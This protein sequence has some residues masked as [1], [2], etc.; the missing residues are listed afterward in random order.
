M[1]PVEQ[2]LQCSRGL[3]HGG[4]SAT[5]DAAACCASHRG[6]VVR[7]CVLLRWHNE[8]EQQASD[9][10][11]APCSPPPQSSFASIASKHTI[12]AKPSTRRCEAHWAGASEEHRG[13]RAKSSAAFD[14]GHC[15]H[16]PHLSVVSA[17]ARQ[18]LIRIHELP[19][20]P[21]AFVFLSRRRAGR[22]LALPALVARCRIAARVAG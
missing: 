10:M 19:S 1:R 13:A 20:S 11:A 17:W 16:S 14:S 18:S 3:Q 22:P 8:R 4:D 6:W 5:L 15:S 2:S 7:E 21:G 9:C 12:S